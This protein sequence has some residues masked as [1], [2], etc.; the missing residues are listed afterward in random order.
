MLPMTAPADPALDGHIATAEGHA[1]AANDAGST[2]PIYFRL[3]ADYAD[4][5]ASIQNGAVDGCVLDDGTNDGIDVDVEGDGTITLQV[6]P[7]VWLNL[8]DFSKIDAGSA[9]A[10]TE[11]KDPGFSQGVTQLSAYHFV[12]TH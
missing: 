3:T 4:I 1:V 9:D 8:V 11:A 2:A 6:L 7:I 12:F 10:P 5:S